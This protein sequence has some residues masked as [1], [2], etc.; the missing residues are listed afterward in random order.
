MKPRLTGLNAI[1]E[2]L[3]VE[4]NKI[5][6]SLESL[7]KIK[8]MI[9]IYS[10]FTKYKINIVQK[11]FKQIYLLPKGA[12]HLFGSCEITLASFVEHSQ[13]KH[14]SKCPSEKSQAMDEER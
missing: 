7:Q 5:K 9:F 14:N 1:M 13:K 8:T 3:L 4:F 11:S 6:P 12:L 10:I 2:A